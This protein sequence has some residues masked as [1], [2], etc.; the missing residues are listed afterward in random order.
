VSPTPR[1]SVVLPFRD[2]A[3]T[4]DAA[5]SS[6]AVQTLTAFECL[7]I[8]DGS[9]DG[10]PARAR[11]LAA[12]DARFRVVR[13]SGGLVHALNTGIAAAR[14]ALV[15]RMDADDLAHPTRLARQVDALDANPGVAVMS[16]LVECFPAASLRAGMRHYQDWLNALR[17]PDAIRNALFVESPIAHPTAMI[18][19][20]ALDAAGGYRDT[21]GPEDY[22]LWLRPLLRGHSAAKV[23]DVLLAWRD[24][25]Q[26]LSRVD[27]RYHRRRFFATKLA[28]F[29][30]AVPPGTVLQVCGAGPTG[31]GWAR[32]LA[33]RGYP[34]R[35]FIDVAPRRWGSMIHGAPVEAPSVADRRDGFFLAAAGSPGSRERI[36][37]WLQQSGLRLWFDYLAVA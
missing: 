8:D 1:V 9:V 4:L 24:S 16:C 27:P 31:R 25:P 2:A 30:V 26:R 3:A 18:R 6:I 32:A 22:D 35:R 19:R 37:S 36:E 21:G 17:T 23:P 34:V 5:V 28:H 13:S 14:A 11:A 15:A 33:A 10:S 7:L 12:R 29:P 20:A